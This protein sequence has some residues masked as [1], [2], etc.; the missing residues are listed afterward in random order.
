MSGGGDWIGF[1]V[2]H[3][4]TMPASAPHARAVFSSPVNLYCFQ[5]KRKLKELQ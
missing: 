4:S 3:L 1:P 5:L 2:N